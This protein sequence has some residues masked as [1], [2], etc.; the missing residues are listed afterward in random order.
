MVA[1]IASYV[2]AARV[3]TVDMLPSKSSEHTILSRLTSKILSAEQNL[4]TALAPL[5]FADL[6]KNRLQLVEGVLLGV[7]WVSLIFDLFSRICSCSRI[8]CEELPQTEKR[9]QL[10]NVSKETIVSFA[11]FSGM[12]ITLMLWA[13]RVRVIAL[14][15]F[16]ALLQ[17]LTYGTYF[18]TSGFGIEKAVKMVQKAKVDLIAAK[19]DASRNLHEHRYRLAIIDIASHIC[20]L[21]WSILGIVGFTAGIV[22]NPLL[23]ETFFLISCGLALVSIGYSL[24]IDFKIAP[25]SAA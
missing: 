16:V 12:T 5:R 6:L 9:V 10:I 24:Y 3:G 18:I 4:N 2:P 19:D 23:M 25:P 15:I 22:F 13:D 1:S 7:G 17:K 21:A 20:T 8:C 14:G 11:S